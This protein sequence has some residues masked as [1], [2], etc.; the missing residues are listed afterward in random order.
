MPKTSK[1]AVAVDSP[2]PPRSVCHF[3]DNR[4]TFQREENE[5]GWI[6][7]FLFSGLSLLSLQEGHAAAPEASLRFPHLGA[8]CL[9]HAKPSEDIG[10]NGDNYNSYENRS[11]VKARLSDWDCAIDDALMSISIQPSL[12]TPSS[13]WIPVKHAALHGA[14]CYDE[15]IGAFQTMLFKFE[16]VP[17]P[18]TQKLRQQYISQSGAEIFIQEI[19]KAQLDDAPH[20]LLN[21]YTGRLCDQE[22]Q[23]DSFITSTEYKEL[24]SLILI[25]VHENLQMEYIEDVGSDCTT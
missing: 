24:L 4:R 1:N 14:Q 3:C 15:A 6:K 11:F 7:P 2:R 12:L 21:T 10:A 16:N 23:I 25:L 9:F 18:Q 17:A 20:R 5:I 22:A 8:F 19:I 13:H